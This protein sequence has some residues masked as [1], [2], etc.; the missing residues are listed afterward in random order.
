MINDAAADDDDD[1]NS[2]RAFTR[3]PGTFLNTFT[4]IDAFNTQ[5]NPMK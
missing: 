3:S 2:Y 4:Y 1:R 5:I